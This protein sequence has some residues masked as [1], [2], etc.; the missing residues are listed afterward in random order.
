MNE[1]PE[2][3]K[4]FFC[5]VDRDKMDLAAV[6]Y[7]YLATDGVYIPFFEYA[8]A[9]IEKVAGD[10]TNR[11]IHEMSRRRSDIF[12]VIVKNAFAQ[13]NGKYYNGRSVG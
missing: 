4:D 13:R 10:E 9:T 8:G 5:I 2:I 1:A 7:S 6:I 3:S 11:D 12:G